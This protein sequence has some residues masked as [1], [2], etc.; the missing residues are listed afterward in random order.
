MGGA[1]WGFDE[2]PDGRKYF[3]IPIVFE[4]QNTSNTTRV[5]RDVS[6]YLYDGKKFVAKMKQMDY[7]HIT[8]R[9]GNSVSGEEDYYFGTDKGSYSF[10]IPP[11]S[12]QRQE[13]EYMYV[14]N[15]SEISDNKFDRAKAGYFD[16]RN[17]ARYFEIRRIDNCWEN[18]MYPIDEEWQVFK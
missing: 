8:H 16:E 10:V 7:L 13:C 6:V 2:N 12:I 17:K 3:V 14:I 9:K 1:T 15:A 11:R 4:F 5:I 18:K